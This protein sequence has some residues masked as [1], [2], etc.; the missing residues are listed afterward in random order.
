MAVLLPKDLGPELVG[1]TERV[2]L[3]EL[4]VERFNLVVAQL[5]REKAPLVAEGELVESPLL[6]A[7]VEGPFPGNALGFGDHVWALSQESVLILV[8]K[9]GDSLT[10]DISALL[11]WLKNNFIY[12]AFAE[13]G[14]H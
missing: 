4:A 3:L 6:V 2:D 9:P 12:L 13:S 8:A 7:G 10:W 14:R 1:V 5:V 11:Q